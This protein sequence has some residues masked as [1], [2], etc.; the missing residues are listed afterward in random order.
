[1]ISERKIHS[2]IIYIYRMQMEA[3]LSLIM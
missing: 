3:L 1:V 2:A